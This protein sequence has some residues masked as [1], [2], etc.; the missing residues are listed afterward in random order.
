MAALLRGNGGYACVARVR[1]A[2]QQPRAA[3]AAV[4]ASC[5]ASASEEEAVVP[6]KAVGWA[7]SFCYTKPHLIYTD[8]NYYFKLKE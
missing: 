6:I 2:L 3:G 7:L 5:V 1:R 8:L 4:A